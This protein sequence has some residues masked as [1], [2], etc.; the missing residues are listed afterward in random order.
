MAYAKELFELISDM[1][2][3]L[4]LFRAAHNGIFSTPWWRSL[5]IPGLFKA[6]P[7]GSYQKR[8]VEI[9]RKLVAKDRRLRNLR[10]NPYIEPDE[11]ASYIEIHRFALALQKAVV[12]L[13]TIATGLNAKTENKPYEKATYKADLAAYRT[14]LA[15]LVETATKM[16]R[17]R[18]TALLDAIP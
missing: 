8:L 4:V 1:D 11:K 14:Y 16:R 2:A 7:Y 17:I 10:H 5:P 13:R 12:L 3:L 6:I 18:D 15:A 9:E